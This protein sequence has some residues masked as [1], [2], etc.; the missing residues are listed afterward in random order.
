MKLFSFIIFVH[1]YLKYKINNQCSCE[2][3]LLQI[4]DAD[5][6]PHM[7]YYYVLRETKIKAYFL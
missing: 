2:L 4:T 7:A 6:F 3:M 1:S 5:P